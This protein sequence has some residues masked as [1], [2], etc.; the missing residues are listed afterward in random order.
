MREPFILTPAPDKRGLIEIAEDEASHLT[1]VLRAGIGD[2]FIAF[3]GNGRGWRAEIIGFDRKAVTAKELGEL[4]AERCP[5]AITL[6]LGAIKGPRMDW[7]VEKAA[8][9]GVSHFIPL[10]S[11]YAVLDPGEGRLRRW[12]GLA[13]AAAKQS[14]RLTLMSFS[15]PKSIEDIHLGVYS[16]IL[17]F[18][19]TEDAVPLHRLSSLERPLPAEERGGVLIL[20]GPEG[21][22][23]EEE[24]EFFRSIGVR[25]VSLGSHPLR[26]ETAVVTAAIAVKSCIFSI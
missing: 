3:D 6:A 22:F 2:K 14:R 16:R 23:S 12:Q 11:R 13:L 18:D 26:S 9:L 8:E 20:I 15:S 17:V 7:A 19:L 25:F 1:R 4:D 10:K 24:R 5:V 21:G